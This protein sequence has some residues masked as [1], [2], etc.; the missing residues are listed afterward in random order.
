MWKA[1]I[2]GV[3]GSAT[4]LAYRFYSDSKFEVSYKRIVARLFLGGVAALIAYLTGLPNSLNSLMIGMVAPE[5]IEGIFAKE[6]EKRT[7]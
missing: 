5:F 1:V 7:G 3:V 6:L 2:Y 4:F